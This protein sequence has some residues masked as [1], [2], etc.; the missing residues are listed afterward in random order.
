MVF[1]FHALEAY[2]NFAGARLDTRFRET[3]RSLS[4]NKK[5]EEV[6]R[7]LAINKQ[8]LARDPWASI[9]ELKW[10]RDR[11]VHAHTEKFEK[12]VEHPIDQTPD[13]NYFEIFEGAVTDESA[14]RVTR[15]IKASVYVLHR[16]LRAKNS[17]DVWLRRDPFDG[18]TYHASG[19]SIVR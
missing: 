1:A 6:L 3:E 19:S 17:E 11:I 5:F 2:L 7:L 8:E 4:F 18:I 16:A 13:L 12:V 14:I 15:D 10:L 9:R